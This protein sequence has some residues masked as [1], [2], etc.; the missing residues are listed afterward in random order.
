MKIPSFLLVLTSFHE[1]LYLH[2]YHHFPTVYF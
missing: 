2:M 1:S